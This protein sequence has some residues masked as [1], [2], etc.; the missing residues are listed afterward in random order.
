VQNRHKAQVYGARLL[1]KQTFPF[2]CHPVGGRLP[3]PA[4]S[5]VAPMPFSK[6]QHLM[7]HFSIPYLDILNFQTTNWKYTLHNYWWSCD[8]FISDRAVKAEWFL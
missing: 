5:P 8:P 2:T 4:L 7:A 1:L 6:P 3:W